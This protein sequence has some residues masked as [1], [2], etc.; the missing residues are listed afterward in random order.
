MR[1]LFRRARGRKVG[2]SQVNLIQIQNDGPLIVATDYWNTPHARRGLFYVSINAG[3][4]RLLVPPPQEG[5]LADMQTGQYVIVTRGLWNGRD[6]M[7]F[8][9]E[10]GSDSPYVIY[11]QVEQVDRLPTKEDEGRSDLRCLVY[12]RAGL[13]LALPAR[14]RRSVH[15]PYLKPWAG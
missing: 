13:A 11:V 6:A 1:S 10:D 7:E 9:F 15:L 3:A 4:V 14:Y 8:L 5:T 2:G 12:T